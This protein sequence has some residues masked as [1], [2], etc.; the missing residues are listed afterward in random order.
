MPD[1]NFDQIFSGLPDAAPMGGTNSGSAA[2][3]V[4]N[5]AAAISITPLGDASQPQTPSNIPVAS[6]SGTN[7]DAIFSALPDKQPAPQPDILAQAADF[8]KSIPTG[9]ASAL[10]SASSAENQSANAVTNLDMTGP[11][12]QQMQTAL[13]QN[14]TGPLYQP[15]GTAGKY[16][17]SVGEF[18]GNPTSYIGPGSVLAKAGMAVLSGLG[19]QAGGQL[20]EGTPYEGFGRFIGSALGPG[21][22][23]EPGA[24]AAEP[25]AIPT[26]SPSVEAAQRLSD[27]TGAPITIPR[28]IASDHMAVQRAGQGI[29]NIPIVGDKIP[30]ATGELVNNLENATRTV[31]DQYGAGSGPNIANRIGLTLQRGAH[32]E[33][34]AATNAAQQSNEALIAA[35]QRNFDAANA[36]VA[37]RENA[38][39]ETT[40]QAVGNMSPQDMG[41]ALIQR[42]RTEE[43]AARANKEAL[44]TAAGQSGASVRADA[45]Q[46]VRSVV[47]QG[48]EDSGV[49]VDPTLTPAA[50]R[51][52]GELQNLSELRI[53]NE[54]VGARLP[55]NGDERAAA[56]SVQGLEQA[57]K[58]L[59]FLSQAASNDADRRAASAVMRQFD[60]WQ[61]DVFENALFSGNDS[62]LNAFRQARAANAAWRNHF[63]NEE[64]DAGR[65]VNRI[66]TG[67]VTPQEVA[68]YIVG[69]GQVGAKGV[70][71]RLLT[72]IA[73]ATNN[74][75]QV[76]Q[77]LRSGIWNRLSQATEGTS[78]KDPTKVAN[79]I[80]EF[81]NG[82]GRDI[83]NR[84][85]SPE[86]RNLMG[87]YADT[88]R[89]GQEARSLIGEVAKTTKPSPMA[90]ASGP[91]QDLA[92]TVIG[93]GGK[94]DEAL[95]R[96]IDSYAKSG[97][98]ADVGT[99]AKIV[100]SIP[101]DE[102]SNL[103]GAIIRNLGQSPRTG[104]FSPDV[105]VSQWNS[106]SPQAK[107]ILFGNAGAQRKA[108]DDIA[109]ISDRLKKIGSRFGNPSGTAQNVNMFALLASFFHA[110][111][112]TAAVGTVGWGLGRFLASPAGASSAARWSTVYERF[113]Q[114]P[115]PKSWALLRIASTNLSG[116]AQSLGF[117]TSP[118]E[119]LRSAGPGP[120][121]AS[122]DNN[123]Q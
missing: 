122:A 43:A 29:R 73:D 79:D 77:T 17:E 116:T 104:Q 1:I 55:A 112:P 114:R 76:M 26:A 93:K 13:E 100:R 90:V 121:P 67:E 118:M 28:A 63:F 39:L 45:V 34:L 53:P 109:L 119:I 72:H 102:R 91:M 40:R 105:F 24:V 52:M 83:A 115:S 70:S 113:L 59:S 23:R 120:V 66:V 8:F 111:L 101:P 22:L 106:Y 7:F 4:G 25:V 75:P 68:N 31:A 9:V 123:H 84:L 98:R 38:A 27:V 58:R 92:D 80:G 46:N 69:A 41:A 42:L 64:D 14:V 82:S 74:D 49:V 35:H 36:D 5:K 44:Y 86:Q 62:A 87:A 33:T 107:A 78:P 15:Q 16:G 12:P 89:N 51:M 57:R 103:A 20:T 54:A 71:S 48:L 56:V 50:S 99:L 96:T 18:V 2:P 47:A 65:V 61:S 108:I 81:L 11:T 21:L 3:F 30:K 60:N 32:A 10:S 85:F 117:K 88:L 110:P 19:S 94:S 95:F 6:G 37:A 97:A